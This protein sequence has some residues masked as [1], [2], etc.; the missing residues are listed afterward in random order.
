MDRLHHMR[1]FVEVAKRKSFRAAAEALDMSNSTLS[2]N[3]AELEK[4]IG[5]RLLQIVPMVALIAGDGGQYHA[6]ATRI[7]ALGVGHK[8]RLLGRI[9]NEEKRA[10]FAHARCVFFGPHDEDYGY[11]T[12]EAMLSSKPVITCT[13]SGGPLEFVIDRETG[14]IAEPTPEAL[15]AA[16]DSL[17]EDRRQAKAWGE[18]ARTRYDGLN[19]SWE[20]VVNKLLA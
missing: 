15:A 10:F 18:A 19:L 2:R 1:L 4:S 17:W 20:T 3:I 11:V 9:S 13:D 7:E 6:L 8:V 14:L 16:F 5:L 12:L